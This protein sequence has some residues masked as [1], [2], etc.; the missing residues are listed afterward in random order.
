MTDVAICC[1]NLATGVIEGPSTG[2]RCDSMEQ[3]V[4]FVDMQALLR[5]QKEDLRVA[6]EDVLDSGRFIG[7]PKVEELE[8][9]LA[10]FV[11]VEHAVACSSGTVAQHLILLALGIGPGDEVLVPD[12]TFA[13]TAEAVL[14]AGATPVFVDVEP[15]FFSMDLSAAKKAL[16]TKVKA[17]VPVSLF[18]Q[19][20]ALGE[21]EQWCAQEGI[22]MIE[23]TCQSLGSRVHGRGSGSFGAAAFTSF[24]PAKPLGGVGDGGMV[25]AG[26]DE[27]AARLRRLRQHGEV[28]HHLHQ[29]MGTN[30]RLDALQCAALLVRMKVFPEELTLRQK[31][32]D[33]YEEALGQRFTTPRLREGYNSTWAQYT[34]RLAGPEQRMGFQDHLSRKGI[35]TVV[36]YPR[37]LHAQAGLEGHS[38]RTTATPV[39]AE[40]CEQVVSLPISAYIHPRDQQR[41]IDAALSWTGN[42]P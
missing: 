14:L 16:S 12:F 22:L 17:V 34:L 24:Y 38:F 32:A 15:D 25:F 30:A 23:D 21:F 13:A 2:P 36:H 29:D 28:G 7:G 19:P 8:A 20:A 6:L 39:T 33:R 10:R 37:P 18:G 40:L 9:T 1:G 41:V 31:A 3:N 5:R 26:D 4:P 27:L 35:P 42:L 11:G